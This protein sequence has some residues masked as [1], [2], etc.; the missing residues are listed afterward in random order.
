MNQ[1]IE[2][3][4]NDLLLRRR[5]KPI[6][7]FTKMGF[8]VGVKKYYKKGIPKVKINGQILFEFFVLSYK[9]SDWGTLIPILPPYHEL[10]SF[11]QFLYSYQKEGET[12]LEENNIK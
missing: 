5:R 1:N 7:E 10:P 8:R 6:D 2:R 12:I 4:A 11:A 3:E 9:V